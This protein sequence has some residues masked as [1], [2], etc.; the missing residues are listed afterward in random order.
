MDSTDISST[1]ESTETEAEASEQGPA[2]FG[3]QLGVAPGNVPV[4][5]SDYETA[6]P[7]DLPDRS[8]FRSY[9]DG[10]YMGY[11]WQCVEF[12]RRWMYLNTGCVFDDVAMAHEIFRLRSVREV[13]TRKTL[14]LYSFLN[15]SRRPP[16]PGS[17]LIWEPGGE[18]EHTGHVAVVTEV[19]PEFIRFA[20]QN[21]GH[22]VWP[23]GQQFARELRTKRTEDGEYWVECSFN[24]ATILGWVIQTD[25]PT[26]A[27]PMALVEPQLF[28]IESREVEKKRRARRSWLNVANADEAAYVDVVGGHRLATRDE[29]QRR[30]FVISESAHDE[31]IRATGE[32]H[33]L[34]MHA[35]DHVLRDEALLAR[36][37]LPRALWP[38]IHE[39]WNNRLNQMITGRFDFAVSPRGIKVYEY[40]ADSAAC[41]M[42]CGKI[43]GRWAE[44]YGCEVGR[45]PGESLHDELVDAWRASDVESPLHIMQ[46]RDPEETYHALFMKETLEAAGIECRILQ[47][48]EG[49]SWDTKGNILDPDG[50]PIRWVWKTWAWETAL[51]QIRAECGDDPEKLRNYKPGQRHA[52]APRLVDVLLRK[53]VMVYE[54]LWTLIP[55]N[56]AILPVLFQLFPECPYLLRT[57][58][59][60]TGSLREQGYVAKP[61]VGRCGSNIQIHDREAGL[62]EQT[63]GA[64]E[65]QAQIFQEL[66]RLPVV[67]GY[68]IQI[69]TFTAAGAWAATCLRADRSLILSQTSDNMPLRVVPDHELRDRRRL[70]R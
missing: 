68:N 27:E 49:L 43:Q 30:Y 25:D 57:S 42:E 13:K 38:K 21:V 17:L 24:D 55:S 28:A 52:G 45:D 46:D 5:S 58:F 29:D 16:E 10:L 32:L 37:N 19:G 2:P 62:I 66:H 4:Y 56:K 60:L 53:S 11:K 65:H 7:R 35:T 12:A 15:G 6:D 31:L 20:E 61:I 47:G 59:E 34:F 39:S 22:R 51:D 18:F 23:E 70:P 1:E 3:V 69:S 8:A 14:P 9:L 64:F 63:S 41:H 54:P 26:H 48:V 67:A 36:F 50:Q 44:H 33:G 40:N